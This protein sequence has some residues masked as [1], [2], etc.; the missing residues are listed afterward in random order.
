MTNSMTNVIEISK[1]I[2]TRRNKKVVKDLEQI[3]LTL[4]NTQ[5]ALTKYTNY[6][7][8]K[9]YTDNSMEYIENIKL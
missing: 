8:I 2:E 5:K 7:I 6:S 9:K 3:L 4:L 1:Y